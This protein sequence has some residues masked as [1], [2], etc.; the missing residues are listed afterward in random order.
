M[1][2]RVWQGG[3]RKDNNREWPELRVKGGLQEL[4]GES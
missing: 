3:G 2:R 1:E 4:G